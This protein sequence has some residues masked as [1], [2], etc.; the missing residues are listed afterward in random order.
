MK[1]LKKNFLRST[2][3]FIAVCWS[4]SAQKDYK[5]WMQYNKVENATLKTEYLTAIEEIVSLGKSETSKIAFKELQSGLDAMLGKKFENKSAT[6]GVYNII[7]GSKESLTSEIKKEIGNFDQINDEGFII[8]SISIKNQ[9]QLVITGKTDIGVLYGV[10]SFLRLLQTNKSI[11]NL[12]IAD[13]P[14][15]TSES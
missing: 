5:L 11:Q 1:H 4:S 2:L 15:Q 8:K 14:K 12:N 3:F 10:Y 6:S 7:I 9:K 13:S